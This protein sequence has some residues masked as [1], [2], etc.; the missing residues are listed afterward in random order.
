MPG[1]FA[2]FQA[3]LQSGNQALQDHGRLPGTGHARH[4]GQTA[5]WESDFQRFHGMDGPRGHPDDA[6]VEEI[7]P[8]G[9]RFQAAFQERTDPGGRV[10]FQLP[11]RP[12]RDDVPAL[13]PCPGDKFD[14][15][16]RVG[17][18]LGVMVHLHHRVAVGD[19]VVHHA[20]ESF[21]IGRM[22]A[23]RRFVQH[24]E[25]ACRAVA[26]RPCQ[27]YPLTL[28]RREGGCGTVQRQVR[29]AQIHQA[30]GRV[31]EGLADPLRHR[32]HRLGKRVRHTF[33]PFDEFGERHLAG[34]G[35]IDSPQE[36]CPGRLGQPGSAAFRADIL[37]QE[38]LHAFHARLVLDLGQRVFHAID[39]TVIGEIHLG[40]AVGL[41][42]LVNYVALFGRAVI[43][44][45]LFLR[46]EVLEG[47]VGPDTHLPGDIFHQR[48]HQRSPRGDGA[49]VDG[50][51]LV[52]HQGGLIHGAN[53]ARSAAATAGAFA[54]E[55]QLFRS[56]RIDPLSA[57]GAEDRLFGSDV[58][59]RL[60]VVTVGA[61]M[62][63]ETGKHESQAV[64]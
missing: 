21:Q 59:R 31:L 3:G 22:Q 50:Q 64:Q 61:A 12:L 17:Q 55:R 2:P 56:G 7:L 46:R 49:L 9:S 38:L 39:G 47:H 8:P 40:K 15:P 57:D 5:F 52:G 45:F 36:R 19:Q 34:I 4:D 27:L 58:Q 14:H 54:V 25:D 53:D 24:I 29:Q 41:F 37:F 43:D 28:S 10:G 1:K 51:R 48:P 30:A 32:P 20:R 11:D 16:V 18:D 60:Q 6:E 26:D 63:R 35:Q 33:D 13:R 62:A 44:D 23:D 42:V